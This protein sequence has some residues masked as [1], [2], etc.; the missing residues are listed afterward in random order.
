MSSQRL[1]LALLALAP[2]VSSP[3]HAAIDLDGPGD[4]T[5]GGGT[6][7][8]TGGGT[9]TTPYWQKNFV[10]SD[11]FGTTTWGAGY[12]VY[13]NVNATPAHDTVKD[14][15]EAK[16]GLETYAK[17]DGYYTS[18]FAVR[19]AGSTE[20]KRRTDA[21]LAAYVG[22]AAIY[23]KSYASETSTYT[24]L[25]V[26]PINWSKTFF[27][28]TVNMSVGFIP[29]TFTVKA[30]GELR[31]NLTGKISNIGIEG[32]ASPGGKASLYASA[33]IGGQ[34]CVDYVGCVG[35]SAGVYSDVKLLEASAPANVSIWW[36]LA[37][38]SAGVLLNWVANAS[39]TLSSLDGEAGVYAEACLVACIH[40]SAKLIEWSGFTATFPIVNQ[41][42]NYC[43][44]GTC[45]LGTV[46]K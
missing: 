41:S 28:K 16:L 6:T 26:T 32:A 33:A 4:E 15:L 27:S 40:E 2:L 31:A 11:L 36:S 22:S 1:L 34:Y 19:L 20:A 35:A 30:T 12:K 13:A 46:A 7:G 44:A 29:V 38:L 10:K 9:T 25:N 39:V 24:F 17:V 45:T 8:G 3:A 42:G 43:L 23:T 5:G 18:L 37:P 21:S 14:K